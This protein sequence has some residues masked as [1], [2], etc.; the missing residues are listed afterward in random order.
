MVLAR[1]CRK[2]A[3]EFRTARSKLL[4][5][6]STEASKAADGF[7]TPCLRLI[8]WL[9][10]QVWAQWD[11]LRHAT[12]VIGTALCVCVRPRCLGRAV[13]KAFALQVLSIGVEPLWFVGAV[14]VFV[15]IS[16]VVQLTFWVG[17]AGQS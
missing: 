14:A 12:A 9:G 2:P 3:K 7:R 5:I 17:E 11:E 4:R 13:R 15:G 6:V 8:G 10:A 1:M 16:V